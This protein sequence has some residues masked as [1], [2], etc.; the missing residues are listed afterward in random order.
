M[1][2]D[3]WV[4]FKEA[5][6]PALVGASSSSSS[7]STGAQKQGKQKQPPRTQLAFY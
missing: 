7:S 1:A 4:L 2:K 3:A 6:H 5:L